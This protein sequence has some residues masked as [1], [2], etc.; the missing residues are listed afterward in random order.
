M[1]EGRAQTE[2]ERHATADHWQMLQEWFHEQ[3][4][5]LPEKFAPYLTVED[6]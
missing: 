4:K 1:R 2:D 3:L 6:L 5:V